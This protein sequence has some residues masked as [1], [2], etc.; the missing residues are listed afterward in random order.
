MNSRSTCEN[1][2]NLKSNDFRKYYEQ[3]QVTIKHFTKAFEKDYLKA[4]QERDSYNMKCKN[5]LVRNIVKIGDFVLIKENDK[6]HLDDVVRGV[7]L[8]VYQNKFDKVIILNRPLQLVVPLEV[9]EEELPDTNNNIIEPA[10]KRK[11]AAVNADTI[12]KLMT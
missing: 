12:R 10:R 7:K 4:L 8:S 1:L 5:H 9:T 11:T 2:E 3:L 6:P